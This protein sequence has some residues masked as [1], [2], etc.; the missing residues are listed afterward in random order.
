MQVQVEWTSEVLFNLRRQHRAAKVDLVGRLELTPSAPPDSLAHP[1]ADGPRCGPSGH[2]F[3]RESGRCCGGPSRPISS[4]LQDP[5]GSRGGGRLAGLLRRGLELQPRPIG[6]GQ[7]GTD[8]D[9]CSWGGL[10]IYL[11]PATGCCEGIRTA[12]PTTSESA[13][14][15][16]STVQSGVLGIE[17]GVCPEAENR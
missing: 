15:K 4:I 17:S 13:N 9:S 8:A 16:P 6:L 11:C 5:G 2:P 1:V 12:A 10:S 3:S 7:F 14:V